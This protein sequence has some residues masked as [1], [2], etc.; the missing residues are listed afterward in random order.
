MPA[1]TTLKLRKEIVQRR[2]A[3]ETFAAVSRDLGISYG[4]VRNIWLRYQQTGQLSPN[5]AACAQPG[6]RKD[7]AIYERVMALKRSYPS[8]GAGLIWV[9]LA[10]ALPE[11]D[12]PCERTLQRWFHRAELVDKNPSDGLREVKVQRGQAVHE[13]WALDA[14]EQMRLLD[15]SHASWVAITDE[16]SGAMLEACAFPPEEVE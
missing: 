4:T 16:G 10:D 6:I 9:E 12:L 2:E 8:W 3:G 5:Y 14:K 1:S 7:Q 13:V 11:A 15:G